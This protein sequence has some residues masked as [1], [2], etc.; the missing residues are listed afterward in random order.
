M[1]WL[2]ECARRARRTGGNVPVRSLLKRNQGNGYEKL[3]V[4]KRRINAIQRAM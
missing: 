4:R 1:R 3:L 2:T